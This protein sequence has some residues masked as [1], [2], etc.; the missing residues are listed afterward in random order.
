MKAATPSRPAALLDDADDPALRASW[1]RLAGQGLLAL[2]LIGLALAA[3]AAA[4]P[5]AGAVI[6]PARIKVEFNRKTVQHQEGGIVRQI[7]VQEGQRVH[8][9][10]ALLVVGDLRSDAELAVQQGA[11]RAA[12]ARR[13]RAAA[14]A[15]LEAAFVVPPQLQGADA[16]EPLARERSL[17]ATRRR[18][19]DEQLGA[20]QAQAR[21]LQAQA[22]ALDARIVA[23]DDSARLAAQELQLNEQLVAQGF[24]SRTRLFALQRNEADYRARAAEF[25][26]ELAGL[27]Q[28]VGELNARGAQLRHQYQSQAAGELDEAAARVRELEQTLRPSDDRAGRQV[29]RAPV[30]GEVMALRVAGIGDVIAPRAP[31]L[32]LV[33]AGERLV[34]EARLRPE[35]V[36]H[37]RAGGAAAVRLLGSDAATL[38]PLPARLTFVSPDRV[39][40]P[41]GREAWFEATA[42]IDAG[43]LRARSGIRLQ[44]GM[45]AELFVTT[46]ERTLLQYLAKPFSV[47]AGRALREP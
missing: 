7:L 15:A 10:E 45:P 24:V 36:E 34:V 46:A 14:E 29:V 12:L 25:R 43:V 20:L 30:D 3:W 41:D 28:R 18:A 44:P 23:A 22:R 17:F 42:E 37:V 35:D 33:P 4:A 32:D 27:Q 1:R 40:S 6:A 11:W 19:L 16:A 13:A 26:A 31:L 9:G 5:L 21:D 47:F 39:S 38:Q 2:A 8:A